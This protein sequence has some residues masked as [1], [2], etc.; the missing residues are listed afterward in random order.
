LYATRI[1]INH[2]MMDEGLI[3]DKIEVDA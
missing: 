1:H 3:I 2:E